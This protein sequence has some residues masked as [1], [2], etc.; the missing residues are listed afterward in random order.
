MKT[1]PLTRGLFATVDDEDYDALSR[2]RWYAHRCPNQD[3]FY[4]RCGLPYNGG[5][6]QVLMHRM[7][8]GLTDPRVGVDHINRNT[9][10]NRRCNLRLASKS[11]NG[12]NTLK[13]SDNKSGFKGV[14]W[15]RAAQKWIAQTQKNGNRIYLGL[16]DTPEQAYEAYCKAAP[17]VHGEFARVS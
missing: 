17:Q 9:L 4:A 1:I 12:G 13:R 16:Y 15:H 8:L 5:T 11:E 6:K 2:Y 10:D 3:Y 14:S 7:I